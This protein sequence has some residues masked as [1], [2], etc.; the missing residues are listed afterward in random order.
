MLIEKIAER[1]IVKRKNWSTQNDE[2]KLP[3]Q[4]L[5]QEKILW[6]QKLFIEKIAEPKIV[7][8]KNCRTE[9]D[10]EKIAGPK[11]VKRRNCG[12]KNCS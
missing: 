4:K 8:R 12:T 7:K 9:N 1:K 11:I 6:D 3:Y 5:F 2:G 10:E